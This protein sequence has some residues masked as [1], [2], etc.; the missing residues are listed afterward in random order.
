MGNPAVTLAVWVRS[1]LGARRGSFSLLQAM[2]SV[3]A[4]LIGAALGTLLALGAGGS[5]DA[6]GY[7]ALPHGFS[8]DLGRAFTGELLGT[9]LLAYTVL[10]VATV[11]RVAGISFCRNG[12]ACDPGGRDVSGS[13]RPSKP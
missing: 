3:A 5:K 13:T 2:R 12:V 4:Q 8:A 10:N 6:V 11:Q 7:P 9:F 1:L